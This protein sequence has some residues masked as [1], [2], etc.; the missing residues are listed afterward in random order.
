MHHDTHP[1]TDASTERPAMKLLLTVAHPDDEA[2]GCGSLLAHATASGVDTVVLCATRGE[3]GEV[4]ASVARTDG[5]PITSDALGRIREDEL[6]AATGLLGVRRVELL[7]WEDSGMDGVA[8]PGS[9]AAAAIADVAAAVA[10]V[11]DEVRPDVVVTLDASDGHRDHAAIRDATIEAVA[12]SEWRPERTYLW[13]LPA[14]LMFQFTGR[15]GIGTP[16]DAITTIVDTS[17]H[18][19]LRWRAMR[20]HASQQPPFDAMAPAL[21]HAFLATD[22]LARI[23][24]PWPGGAIERDW[25]ATSPVLVHSTSGSAD[26]STD[27]ADSR[28]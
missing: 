19:D 20:A 18:V 5:V 10:A 16:D 11:I 3:R 7:H 22:H 15:S 28:R 2:F 8:P 4:S 12:R 6:R 21:Q 25:V 27:L 1:R 9:L 26:G 17:E 24:P 13:C 23:D 14:S